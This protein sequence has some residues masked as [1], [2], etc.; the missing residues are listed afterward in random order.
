MYVADLAETVI[1]SISDN[2]NLNCLQEDNQVPL[3]FLSI[4][5]YLIRRRIGWKKTLLIFQ[6]INY[7]NAKSSCHETE[8]QI[9]G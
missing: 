8:Q 7:I 1:S 3:N 2:M 9:R 5:N 4:P 6:N